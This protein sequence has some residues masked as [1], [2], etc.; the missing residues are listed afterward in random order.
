MENKVA[1]IVPYF[2]ELPD[3]FSE[4]MYTASFLKNKVDFLLMTDNLQNDILKDPPSNIRIFEMTFDDFRKKIQSKFD[5]P[6]KLKYPYKICDFR[7][8][9]GYIF[10]DILKEY[11][12][13]GNCDIDQ[14]W[15]NVSE[16][17]TDDILDNFEK[18]LH[19][20]H[21]TLYKNSEKMNTMFKKSGSYAS[22]EEVYS[23][24]NLYAFDEV[25][26]IV[27][28]CKSNGVKVYFEQ[29]YAD[30]DV[31]YSRIKLRNLPNF[32]KQIV[33][34]KEGCIFRSYIENGEVKTESYIYAHFQKKYPVSINS[35]ES[36]PSAFIINANSFIDIS[37]EEINLELIEKYSDYVDEEKDEKDKKKY[38][39]KKAISFLKSSPKRK[40]L[41]I[42]K[43]L[44]SE[45]I[46]KP[47]PEGQYE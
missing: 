36:K 28:I 15:G 14:I 31:K 6:I 26:G 40:L 8:A 7:P 21:F 42:R 45:K 46:Y 5:F 34:W 24:D 25:A 29:I 27:Q 47:C 43:K 16:F 20:G 2:G 39:Q 18:I 10:D 23:S 30:I 32:K 38:Y 35:Y 3:Y 37:N 41:W 12:F 19:L 11:D 22:F 4:W 44:K 9:Y 33:Y 13:W 1:F 17:V